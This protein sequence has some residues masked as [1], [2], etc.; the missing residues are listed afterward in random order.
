MPFFAF[1]DNLQDIH[2]SNLERG[3]GERI[4]SLKVTNLVGMVHAAGGVSNFFLLGK[5]LAN[6][7][8]LTQSTNTPTTNGSRAQQF[9]YD[10]QQ[11]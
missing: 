2:M 3:V 9:F 6:G 10:R 4:Q 11:P 5:R 8:S 1:S 7:G